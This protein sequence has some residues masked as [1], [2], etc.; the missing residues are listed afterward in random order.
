[1]PAFVPLP[2]RRR[3]RNFAAPRAVRVGGANSRQYNQEILTIAGPFEHDL[4]N[5][6]ARS[7]A[8]A[9]RPGR[10]VRMV[11]ESALKAGEAVAYLVIL[12]MVCGPLAMGAF[13]L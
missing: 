11:R 5:E 9:P 13:G 8:F 7:D 6:P 12:V 10:H 1:M 3:R 4:E 2:R